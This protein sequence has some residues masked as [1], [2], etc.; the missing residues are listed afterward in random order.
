MKDTITTGLEKKRRNNQ[1]SDFILSPLKS[2]LAGFS[3]L[4]TVLY[5]SNLVNYISG[6]TN[7]F[8]IMTG[9]IPLSLLGFVL[10][11]L[12]RFLSNFIDD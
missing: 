4:F 5:I 11:F 3:I 12:I 8:D 1:I 6:E 7:S 10:G 9:D 2:G